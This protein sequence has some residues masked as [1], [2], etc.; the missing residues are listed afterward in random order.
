MATSINW[1]DGLRAPQQTGYASTPFGP[2]ERV[3]LANGQERTR[4]KS[5]RAMSTVTVEY[6]FSEV[7]AAF[8]EAWHRDVLAYGV[9]SFNGPIKNG[10]GVRQCECKFRG[11][12]STPEVEGPWLRYSAVMDLIDRPMLPAGY[13]AWPPQLIMGASLLDVAVNQ[14]APEA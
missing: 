11:M 10:L 4:L 6:V 8:F 3:P 5:R 13:G 1:P 12:Y 9:L 14:L 7:E 2:L